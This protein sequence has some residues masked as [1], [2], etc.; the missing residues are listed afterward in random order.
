MLYNDQGHNSDTPSKAV[1][2]NPTVTFYQEEHE[3]A[4]SEERGGQVYKAAL[5]VL[6]FVSLTFYGYCN[7]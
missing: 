2:I 4:I 5:K 6:F 3:K 7:G 1:R